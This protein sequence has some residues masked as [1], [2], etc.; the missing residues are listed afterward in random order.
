MN[1]IK[2]LALSL[3]SLPASWGSIPTPEGLFRNANNQDLT[4]NVVS[5]KFMVYNLGSST[6]DR[7]V[8]KKGHY[9]KL[10]F[11]QGEESYDLSQLEFAT[12][13][14]EESSAISGKFIP[15]VTRQLSTDSNQPRALFYGVLSM[16][17]LNS[18]KGVGLLFK[19][20]NK[21]F[22]FNDQ[23][24][25]DDQLRLYSRQKRYLSQSKGAQSPGTP[26]PFRPANEEER[27]KVN[28]ILNADMYRKTEFVHLEKEGD[29]Y[30]WKVKLDKI[31]GR[32]T[33]DDHR[34]EHLWVDTSQGPVEYDFSDYVLFDGIHE[35]PKNI[36]IKDAQGQRY[37]IRMLSLVHGNNIEKRAQESAKSLDSA[38]VRAT[39]KAE[40]SPSFIY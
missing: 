36:V 9:Y 19:K 5:L 25:N 35:L 8:A 17:A 40:D 21:D 12:G 29:R 26:T 30:F 37:R 23:L 14:I 39:P 28:E 2:I 3:F 10:V 15:R 1:I 38:K 16:L 4:A 34:I 20:I 7:P 32:F 24:M 18:S 22:P 13:K 6:E 11:A 31:E 27:L 33:N